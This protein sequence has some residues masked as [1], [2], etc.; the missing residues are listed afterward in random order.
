M[1]FE[2]GTRDDVMCVYS[3]K[4]SYWMAAVGFQTIFVC[5]CMT[6]HEI[7]PLSDNLEGSTKIDTLK[8]AGFFSK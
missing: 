4:S 2:V 7:F 5:M 8:P 3:A 6:L 1:I